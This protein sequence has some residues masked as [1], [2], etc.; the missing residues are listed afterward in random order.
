MFIKSP[1][2]AASHSEHKLQ[3]SL[4]I[5]SLSAAALVAGCAAGPDFKRPDAPVAAGYAPK[6]A[7][8][9]TGGAQ[10]FNTAGDIPF[11]WWTVFNSPQIDSLIKRAFKANPSIESAQAALRQ[12]QEYANA[13]QGFFY[14][15]VGAGY[16][17]SR[18]KQAG[19]M[20][21]NSP[22]LQGNGK[23]IQAA[24]GAPVSYNFH[25]AQ[26]TVGYV[27]D[28]FGMNRRQMESAEAQ[29]AMQ[30]LQLEAAYITLSTNVVAAAIQEASLRAQ[31]AATDR[32]ISANRET[33]EILRKQLKFGYVSGMEV[34]VQELALAQ[35]EQSL[36]PLQKQ[37]EQ[38]RDLL[39]AL[40]G[41]QPNEDVAEKFELADLHLPQE[42]PL[43]LPSRIVEQR[44]DVRAAEEQLHYASA[45][46]GVAIANTMPQFVLTAGMGGMA[47]SPDW[48]FRSGGG[49]FDLAANVSQ[50]LFDGGTLRA[51]SRAAEQALLQAGAQYRGTVIAALQNVADTLHAIQSDADALG[52]AQRSEQAAQTSLNLTRT[53]YQLGYVPYQIQL[54]A[55]QSHQLAVINLIQAQ[56]NRLGDSAALYQALGG[57]WW[58]R[59]ADATKPDT[60]KP[61][62]N[63]PGTK[64]QPGTVAQ[65]EIAR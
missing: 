27:P 64:A 49:F 48:M 30:R 42:L 23:T 32:I 63:K 24:P 29:V 41:N 53:Q 38:T 43:S 40:A 8:D 36:P 39:R 50:T 35:A 59:P 54:A 11:D 20:S 65:G 2:A 34:A 31:L 12:A 26:L 33:L 15:T 56:T 28:V 18:T 61:D 51:R 9:K 4:A 45:Q 6:T 37:L 19:N 7:T 62:T 3:R 46:A 10:R 5:A 1:P 21:G 47:S 57:G 22:G 16:S 58:N 17:P 55:E 13:Q 60:N 52:A 25:V 14:P 44:P